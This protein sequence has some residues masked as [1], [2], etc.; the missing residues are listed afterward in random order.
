[1]GKRFYRFIVPAAR[2]VTKR[3]KTT[4]EVPF[5]GEPCVFVCNHERASGPIRMVL[6]FPEMKNSRVWI[7]ADPLNRKTVPAY[8]RQDHW[9]N[10]EAKLAPLY[11]AIIP[12]IVSVVL[13]PILR[14]IPNIP[15]YHDARAL[16]TMRESL[17]ALKA[18]QSLIIFPE[19]PTGYHEHDTAR[20]NEGFLLILDL[21]EK[22]NGKPLKIWPVH[23]DMQAHEFRVKAPITKALSVPL[24]AQV[25][26]I[27]ERI[28]DGIFERTGGS[29]V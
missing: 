25:P 19:L 20:I 7:F 14:S 2:L 24:E 12:P 4:W 21:Y 16:S 15:V 8:V 28:L 10:E 29:H 26:A 9:W 3:I 23:L 6:D 11:N 22:A 13:P 18:G 5:D 27:C 17:K 1:M